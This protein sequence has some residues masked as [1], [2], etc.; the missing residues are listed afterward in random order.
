MERRRSREETEGI[1]TAGSRGELTAHL[2]KFNRIHLARNGREVRDDEL[3]GGA[4][5][6][7]SEREGRG[8]HWSAT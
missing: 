7:A 3:T 4:S 6:S 1:K 8:V 5:L 2:N